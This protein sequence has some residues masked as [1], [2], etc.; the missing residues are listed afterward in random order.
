MKKVFED[1]RWIIVGSFII[2]L[3]LISH[4]WAVKNKRRFIETG[5]NNLNKVGHFEHPGIDTLSGLESRL[6]TMFLWNVI[7]VHN[8]LKHGLSGIKIDDK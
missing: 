8:Q 3:L 4:N 1:F 6:T 5:F 2:I 7:K